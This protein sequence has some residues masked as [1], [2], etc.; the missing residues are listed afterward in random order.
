MPQLTRTFT[1]NLSAFP[2]NVTNT[3]LGVDDL[4][5]RC[6][7][8]GYVKAE[9]NDAPSTNASDLLTM[10]VQPTA[11]GAA[12]TR[13][14]NGEQ[15]SMVP[16]A[17]SEEELSRAL[18]VALSESPA[19]ETTAINGTSGIYPY[20]VAFDPTSRFDTRVRLDDAAARSGY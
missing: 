13:T 2:A 3:S 5:A 19:G 1:P 18:S 4:V 17:P 20:N 16:L 12:N 6:Y 8:V 14:T 11:T 15:D 9:S 7:E 10:A